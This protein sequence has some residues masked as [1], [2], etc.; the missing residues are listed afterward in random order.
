[1]VTSGD[2]AIF[3]D[4]NVLIYAN[5]SSAPY[6]QLAIERLQN[7]DNSGADLWISRQILREFIAALTRPQTFVNIQPPEVIVERIQFFEQR[8]QIAEDSFQVT[9][10]LLNLLQTIPMGGR[11]IHDANIV[12]TL[13]TS[14]IDRLLTHNV[15]DFD[16]F[17][18]LITVIPLVAAT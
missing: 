16:R 18:D 2:R 9:A 6:H 1:M 4:T 15:K 5:V 3:V 13:L 11:Q 10:R 7:L 12:A 17:S 8:F 14:G